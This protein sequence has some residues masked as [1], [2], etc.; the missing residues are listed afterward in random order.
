MRIKINLF[1]PMS[2][3]PLLRTLDKQWPN[4]TVSLNPPFGSL[5]AAPCLRFRPLPWSFATQELQGGILDQRNQLCTHTKGP[6]VSAVPT[7]KV[8]LWG[9]LSLYILG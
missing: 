7:C 2:M 6:A 3:P 4:E 1:P 8:G 5:M 9:L